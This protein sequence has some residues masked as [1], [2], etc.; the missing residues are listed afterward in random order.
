[1]KFI[2]HIFIL[3]ILLSSSIATAQ[4]KFQTKVSKKTLGQNERLRVDFSMNQ[5][6]DNFN[7]P[8]FDGFNVVNGK[9]S[10]EK[11]YS[12]FLQPKGKGNFTIKPATIEINGETFKTKPIAIKVTKAIDKPK[13]PNDP[14]VIVKDN[15]HLVAEVKPLQ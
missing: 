2:K 6:G 1:M 10:F 8:S 3:L 13:D 14:D 15:I 7:P 4:V 9:R 5:D 12:Y 11:T